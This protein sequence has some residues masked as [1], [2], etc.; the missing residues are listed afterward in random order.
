MH[1]PAAH[2]SSYANGLAAYLLAVVPSCLAALDGRL[3]A[4]GKRIPLKHALPCQ[5][6]THA[7][8]NLA[9]KQ[10][11]DV[12]ANDTFHMYCWRGPGS[13]EE[14]TFLGLGSGHK[15]RSQLHSIQRQDQH[16]C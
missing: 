10:G 13:T 16:I 7:C 3:G 8:M 11:I 14:H 1:C 4:Q 2:H 9:G 15:L 5:Q 12:S 6:L